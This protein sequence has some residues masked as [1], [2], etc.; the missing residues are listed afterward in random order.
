[1]D[2]PAVTPPSPATPAAA[3]A[4]WRHSTGSRPEPGLQVVVVDDVHKG[5]RRG[6]EVVHALR[7]VSFGLRE[8]EIVGLVGPS[9]SGKTTLL[10]LMC[11][12]EQ[13]DAG[14]LT[15]AAGPQ[16][17]RHGLAD[18][19]WSQVAILPQGLGL[20]EELT[21]R[22][23]VELPLHLA[24]DADHPEPVDELLGRLGLTALADRSPREASLGEQQRA[25]LARSLVLRPNLL[26]ADEPTAHQDARSAR[27]ALIELVRAARAGT[28]LLIATHNPEAAALAD[29]ILT[30]RDGRLG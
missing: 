28:S 11:G 26:L 14:S 29:R 22:E 24:D 6:S 19:A 8:G 23:N 3:D 16:R 5:Y 15:W 10:N 27:M 12:W 18:L 25:A 20:M 2:R 30:I 17:R 21:V 1:M 13:P 9:G 4:V 7:G